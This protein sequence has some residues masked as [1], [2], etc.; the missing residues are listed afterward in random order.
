MN[1]GIIVLV[2][3]IG[4][5]HS[6]RP[7]QNCNDC[8]FNRNCKRNKEKKF[9]VNSDIWKDYE[10]DPNPPIDIEKRNTVNILKQFK[11][12]NGS[13]LNKNCSINTKKKFIKINDIWKDYNNDPNPPIDIEKRNNEVLKFISED[14]YFP[15]I[16]YNHKIYK[17]MIKI[18]STFYI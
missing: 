17:T 14:N 9:V 18:V 5:V 7:F 4:I 6:L 16:K 8:I 13:V 12:Y 11:N 1:L 3:Q 15:E 10:N 2:I